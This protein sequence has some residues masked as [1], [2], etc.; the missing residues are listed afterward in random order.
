VEKCNG[1]KIYTENA[2][3]VLRL[4]LYGLRITGIYQVLKN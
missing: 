3:L 1:Y 4:F 2:Y